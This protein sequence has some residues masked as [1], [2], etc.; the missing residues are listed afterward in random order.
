MRDVLQDIPLDTAIVH[1]LWQPTTEVFDLPIVET[2]TVFA[3]K[4]MLATRV[5]CDAPH[6]HL[7]F[8]LTQLRDEVPLSQYVG[9]GDTVLGRPKRGG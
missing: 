6:M 3:L 4:D 8:G 5:A 1:V 2:T 9:H 7:V